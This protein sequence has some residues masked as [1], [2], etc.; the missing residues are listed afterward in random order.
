MSEIPSAMGVFA[1]LSSD[2]R[3]KEKSVPRPEEYDI[4]T[5][6]WRKW[7]VSEAHQIKKFMRTMPKRSTYASSPLPSHGSLTSY[8]PV[9]ERNYTVRWEWDPE[10]QRRSSITGDWNYPAAL[11]AIG[12]PSGTGK[13]ELFFK[14][15]QSFGSHT[16]H[17]HNNHVDTPT[18]LPA[19][20]KCWKAT[21]VPL[22]IAAG[23]ED[24][25]EQNP[26]GPVMR[27]GDVLRFGTYGCENAQDRRPTS[28]LEEYTQQSVS[29]VFH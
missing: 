27:R 9:E 26:K 28:F 7:L 10:T 14:E 12:A 16:W 20:F 22:I 2:S 4:P 1:L 24:V 5:S 29:R 17:D 13:P 11:V 6:N 21:G 19:G 23:Y 25:T 18:D 3:N 15:S 8:D